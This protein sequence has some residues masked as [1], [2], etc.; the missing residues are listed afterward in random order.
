MKLLLLGLLLIL[1]SQT[2]SQV[3]EIELQGERYS[4]SPYGSPSGGRECYEHAYAGPFSKEESMN[5]CG[6]VGTVMP[7]KCA[8]K[9]YAGRYTKTQSLELCHRALSE[10]PVDCSELLYS[11]PFTLSE[12]MSFC[13]H[14]TATAQS[15]QCVL[16]AYKGPYTKEESLR[17][18]RNGRPAPK[19]QLK[20]SQSEFEELL[21][22]VNTKAVNQNEYK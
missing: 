22:E 15:A 17:L 19:F 1:S 3:L 21:K 4:C 12:S 2:Y 5:L 11:G 16:E 6:G 20:S 10:G 13:S 7:A 14:P 8:R 9:A 18:C